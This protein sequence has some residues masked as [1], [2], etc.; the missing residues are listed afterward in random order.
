M[1]NA[2]FRAIL[3]VAN[4]TIFLLKRHCQTINTLLLNAIS[5][6]LAPFL[7]LHEKHY[8]ASRK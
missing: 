4:H 3:T 6:I 7:G 1:Q 8:F 2:L 5:G